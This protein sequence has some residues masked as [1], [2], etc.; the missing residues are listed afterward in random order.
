MLR[1]EASVLHYTNDLS[2]PVQDAENQPHARSSGVYLDWR[3][4]VASAL[5][6][7]ITRY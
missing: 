1:G 5:Q 4:E 2:P 3:G 6:L 7:G